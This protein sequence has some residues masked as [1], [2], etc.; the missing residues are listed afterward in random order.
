V[1]LGPVGR[2]DDMANGL[3]ELEPPA[4]SVPALTTRRRSGASA[5]VS[6]SSPSVASR[7][8]STDSL[9]TSATIASPPQPAGQDS[10]H[11][12]D[13]T[14]KLRSSRHSAPDSP[15]TNNN[16]DDDD[17]DDPDTL[18]N[19]MHPDAEPTN[20]TNP[21][22]PTRHPANTDEYDK[23]LPT[24]A[25]AAAAITTAHQRRKSK[26]PDFKLK[27]T[28]AGHEGPRFQAKAVKGGTVLKFA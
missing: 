9:D 4:S 18:S 12:T 5:H 20:T 11:T 27:I 25:A 1:E 14:V 22:T 10:Y 19:T 2:S 7:P 17:D 26:A 24:T 21:P 16:N 15:E 28:R 6:P 3:T 13:L 23:A 8:S